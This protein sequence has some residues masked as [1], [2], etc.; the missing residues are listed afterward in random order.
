MA[1]VVAVPSGI[2][3]D[4]NNYQLSMIITVSILLLQTLTDKML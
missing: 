1:R 4:A 3:V 2:I